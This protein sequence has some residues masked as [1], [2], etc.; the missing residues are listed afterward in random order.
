VDPYD[1]LQTI[2]EIAIA[3]AGFAGIVAVMGRRA[4]GEWIEPD[5]FRLHMLLRLSFEVVLFAFLPLVLALA[6]L[7]AATAWASVSALRAAYVLAA[8]YFTAR[9]IRDAARVHPEEVS[10]PFIAA[11]ALLAILVLA[12]LGFNAVFAREAWPYVAAMVLGLVMPFLMFMRLL[13]GALTPAARG[14]DGP[15]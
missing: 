15:P 7:P 12:L 8:S 14:D 13:N 5:L 6:S 11:T 10:R 1:A 2:A 9:R 4:G 3:I